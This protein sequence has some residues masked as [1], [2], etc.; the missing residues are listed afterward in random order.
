MQDNVQNIADVR[1]E[2]QLREEIEM[3]MIREEI[4][5]AQKA[6][7]DWILKGDRNTKYFQTLV[8]QRRA[9][10]KILHLKIENGEFTEDLEVIENTLVTH[11]KD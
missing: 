1:K 4:I 11:F 9:R 7:N 6:R 2:R 5:W 10:N 8:K 3:L